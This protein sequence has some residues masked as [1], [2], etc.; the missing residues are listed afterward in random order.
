VSK[1]PWKP[2]YVLSHDWLYLRLEPGRVWE[3]YLP[4]EPQPLRL[5][6]ISTSPE[7]EVK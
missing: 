1:P 7:G 5:R 4:D 2:G 6:L 3:Y